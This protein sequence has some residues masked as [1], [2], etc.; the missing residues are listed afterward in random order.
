MDLTAGAGCLTGCLTGCCGWELGL[1]E[2]VDLVVAV[3]TVGESAGISFPS[4]MAASTS[5]YG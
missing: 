1:L 5:S 4:R 3:V 2:G